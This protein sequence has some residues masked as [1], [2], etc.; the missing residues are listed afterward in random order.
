MF[1][2]LYF[3]NGIY[4]YT[5]RKELLLILSRPSIDKA[6]KNKISKRTAFLASVSISFPINK[7]CQL[8]ADCLNWR[9]PIT[10]NAQVNSNTNPDVN[11]SHP[12]TP[13]PLTYP[14]H[15]PSLSAYTWR[16]PPFLS[17]RQ[18]VNEHKSSKSCRLLS[19]HIL[20]LAGNTLGALFPQIKNLNHNKKNTSM[21]QALCMCKCLC[22]TH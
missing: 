11:N 20:I 1:T 22:V 21:L 2:S 5:K 9:L 6:E 18:V 12:T 15:S 16:S 8:M 10:G 19:C 7:F 13:D 14:R 3:G 17:D 4:M